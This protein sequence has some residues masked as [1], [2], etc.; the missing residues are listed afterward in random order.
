MEQQTGT[1]RAEAKTGSQKQES[2]S[3]TT[4]HSI[5]TLNDVAAA[6]SHIYYTG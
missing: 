2:R 4:V 5:P 6:L 1:W 3:E